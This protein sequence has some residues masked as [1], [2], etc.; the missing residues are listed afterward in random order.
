MLVRAR[1]R[2][3]RGLRF[4]W[5]LLLALGAATAYADVNAIRELIR[6]GRFAEAAAACDRE[7][8]LS[9]ANPAVWT[10][11]G[12]ALQGSGAAAESLAAFRSALKLDAH[13]A[14]A[15]QAAAQ[16]EFE[17]RDAR[18]RSTLETILQK[19]PG[20]ATAHAMLG[21]LAFEREDCPSVLR[22]YANSAKPPAV[23]WRVGVCAFQMEQWPVAAAEFS[24]LL[25]L[26]EHGPTRYNLGLTHWRA[27]NPEATLEALG[28]L[29][30]ADS[31]SLRAAALRASKRIPEALALLQSAIE[32]YPLDERLLLDLALL[33][34]D[35]NSIE[36]GVSVL[37]AAVARLPK[38][39]R[40]HTAL[41]VFHVRAGRFEQ[42]NASFQTAIG[43]SPGA[44][45][46]Q[47]ATASTLMQMGLA[48]DAVRLLR[49]LPLSEPMVALTLARALLLKNASVQERAEA[50]KLLAGVITREPSL[51]AARSLL[52]KAHA[53]DGENALAVRQLEEA[54]RLDPADRTA[55][56]QL[57]TVYRK[58]GRVADAN[59]LSVR[60]R[61][62]L[63]QE[64]SD[65][66][67]SQRYSLSRQ[68]DR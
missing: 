38:S 8:K 27:G 24:A 29:D 23:R 25:A 57:L 15:L 62:L 18:A 2:W 49:P 45:M 65:E 11:K 51:A 20:N 58:L 5:L 44:G 13:Y 64:K 3:E 41:G 7:L 56:F 39:V 32:R 68:E 22:H 50:K 46:G 4:R 9:P 10:L 55:V 66:L 61:Q 52:G 12:F 19:D 34:L 43:M 26:R 54:L 53:Q 14:P 17:A 6:G 60:L 21:E 1:S 30:D 31:L 33:C 47:V 28:K 63:A 36:L 35:Q 48:E 67:E 42:G 16:L 59:R 37:D 40:L